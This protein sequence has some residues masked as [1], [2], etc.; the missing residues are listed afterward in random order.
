MYVSL[1]SIYFDEHR[2]A[3]KN[4]HI[5]TKQNHNHF[6]PNNWHMV[7]NS[8]F[9]FYLYT[10]FSWGTVK[11]YLLPLK[12]IKAEFMRERDM[13]LLPICCSVQPTLKNT[14]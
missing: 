1:I 14:G 6:D 11:K 4:E 7:Y 3:I 2:I 9:Q 5:Y 12:E 8:G 10:V 13:Y